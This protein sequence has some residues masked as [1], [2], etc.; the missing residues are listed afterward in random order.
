MTT[1]STQ[2][3]LHLKNPNF[4][5]Q[6]Q[7]FPA[8]YTLQFKQDNEL[9]S[10]EVEV[11]FSPADFEA[12]LNQGRALIPS[13]QITLTSPQENATWREAAWPLSRLND[14][15]WQFLIR[16]I[17]TDR[18]I[19]TLW[20]LKDLELARKVVANMSARAGACLTEELVQRFGGKS[21]DAAPAR[22]TQTAH[23]CLREMLDVLARLQ[24]EGQIEK[25]S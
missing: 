5:L 18:L 1:M 6:K 9:G 8:S 13:P 23:E 16:E 17:S 2:I 7:E 4:S 20:F 19:Y 21:P 25:W 15:E 3:S 24:A 14:N 11:E 22:E 12:L 10:V